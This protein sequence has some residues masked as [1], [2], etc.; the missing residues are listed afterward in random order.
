MK[1]IFAIAALAI[2]F[3][4]NCPDTLSAQSNE[5]TTIQ[6]GPDWTC[7]RG[8]WFPPGMTLPDGAD[9]SPA[10]PPPQETGCTTIQPG[11]DWTCARGGWYPPGMTPPGGEP[12][13]TSEPPPQPTGCTTIQ[14]GPGWTCSRG[15]WF[16]PGMTPPGGDAPAPPAPAPPPPDTGCT[17]M[18]PGPGWTCNN[19]GWLPPSTP[20]GWRPFPRTAER[21]QR[22]SPPR[23]HM[24]HSLRQWRYVGPGT[25]D[26]EL[27][28]RRR[29]AAGSTNL[30]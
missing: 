27:G 3:V 28:R 11:P 20:P 8:G 14:P 19:G 22:R 9:P 29:A 24:E 7:V 21:R 15:G 5:C 17:T 2:T 13:R 1:K 18:Q 6:P 12:R 4:A 16:P 25:R 30:G 10:A 26:C 23:R